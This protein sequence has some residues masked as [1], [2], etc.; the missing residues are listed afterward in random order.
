MSQQAAK[1]V[2]EE[3]KKVLGVSDTDLGGDFFAL[4]GNSLMAVTLV[5]RIEDRLEVALPIETLF[6]DGTLEG[7]IAACT[8]TDA[9]DEIS[10][11]QRA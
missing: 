8:S 10:P 7:L 4:G 11:V 9:L 6:V 2:T 3:W 5:M 1:I